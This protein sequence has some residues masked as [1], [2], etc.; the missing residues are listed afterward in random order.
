MVIAVPL[1][2]ASGCVAALIPRAPVEQI[3]TEDGTYEVGCLTCDMG[4]GTWQTT[5]RAASD[6][7]CL[8]IRASSPQISPPTN[9]CAAA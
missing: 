4:A 9:L 8:W 2:L 6:G 1:M 5:E 3:I 7:Q